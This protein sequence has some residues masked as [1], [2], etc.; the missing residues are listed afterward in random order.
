MEFSMLSRD[1]KICEVVSIEEATEWVYSN[2]RMII[3][4]AKEYARY[5]PYDIEDYVQDAY[6]AAVEAALCCQKNAKLKFVGV[7]WVVFRRFVA[8]VTPLPDEARI[9]A[10]KKKIAAYC[11]KKGLPVPSV[12]DSEEKEDKKNYYSGGTSM[13]FPI[14]AQQDAGLENFMAKKSKKDAV[15]L[16]D[17]VNNCKDLWSPRETVAMKY[18][19]GLTDEGILT[20]PEIAAKMGVG[21]YTAREFVGRAVQK[22]KSSGNVIALAERRSHSE[23]A[24]WDEPSVC[25]AGR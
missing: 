8:K 19:L 20:I 17:L 15:D 9:E 7:F 6:H 5:A 16:D 12:V 1:N 14:N 24:S 18:R 11:H 25:F 21:K 23:A 3:D 22:A 4:R 2:K 10:K 13:S